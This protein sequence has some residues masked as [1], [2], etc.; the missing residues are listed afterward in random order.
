MKFTLKK[1]GTLDC[2]SDSG[3]VYE[4]SLNKCSC[5][6]YSYRGTCKHFQSA[7]ADGWLEKLKIAQAQF[8]LEKSPYIV[9][10]RKEAIKQYLIKN[11]IKAVK[12]LV[13]M[14]ERKVTQKMSPK[15]F[16]KL[17]KG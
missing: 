10:A 5:L 1:D 2:L 8:S 15:Q 6:G 12:S 4:V 11:K 7:Q 16:L 13:D 3:S 17:A 14:L 9:E